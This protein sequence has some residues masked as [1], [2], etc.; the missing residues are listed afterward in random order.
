[1]RI[2]KAVITAAGDHHARL[3]LQT[4]VDRRGEIRTALRLMLDEVADSG[5]EEVAII[6]RPGQQEAYL[7]AAGPHAARLVFFEQSHPR[8]YGDAIL[9]ARDFAAGESFLHLVSDHLY[10]SRTNRLC[11][12]QLVEAATKYECS[13]SA[14]QPTRENEVAFFGTV[15]GTPLALSDNLYEVNTVIEKP[16]PTIAEQCLIVA[17]Q[18]AG[19][20]LC[21]FGMHVLTPTVFTLLQ[22]SLDAAP[23]GQ[24]IDLSSSLN[25]LTRIERYLALEIDGSRYNI[26]YKYGLLLAQLAFSLSGDDRDLILTELVNLLAA[27]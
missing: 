23:S 5:I 1:M 26:S 14:I 4:L 7:T 19:Y 8:G 24:S 2:R 6:V 21:M 17:G 12:Q 10:L 22:K 11:A 18:R 3:P 13:V 9:R 25:Q 20:Y 16:T 15:G 27:R